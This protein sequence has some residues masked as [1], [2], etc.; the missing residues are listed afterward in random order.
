M[1]RSIFFDVDNTLISRKDNKMC[2]STI[3]AIEICKNNNIDLAIATGRSLAMV[4][5][6]SFY[7]MFTTIV[8]ANG[9][10]IT[11]NDEI[12]YKRYMDKKAIRSIISFFEEFNIPYCIHL[13]DRS[14]GKINEAW[15]QDFSI[16]Y[17]MAIEVLTNNVIENIDDY[18]VFQINAHIKE[19]DY[20]FLINEYQA[21]NFVKLIDVEDGYDIFNKNCSKG[22]AI[23]YIKDLNI[24]ENRKYYAFGDGF[25]DLEMF[26][27]V[28]FGIAMG[29]ACNEL[30]A[31]ANLVT[32][33]INNQGI[34][35]ALKKLEII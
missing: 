23:K 32:S 20:K 11:I 29:N 24:E 8:S 19:D 3:K 35:N 26:E 2:E 13:L 4:K 14:V 16:K 31:K 17:N 28:D 33:N 27:E 5:Q 34:Y 25:N 22:S 21:F 9:S 1:I 30:K 7:K 15:V 6:E 10:L 12:V 18:E